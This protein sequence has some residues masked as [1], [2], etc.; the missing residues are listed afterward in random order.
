[1][2]TRNLRALCANHS[3]LALLC[4]RL[5]ALVAALTRISKTCRIFPL[6]PSFW[7]LQKHSRV[8]TAAFHVA[9]PLLGCR[10]LH[11]CCSPDPFLWVV[12]SL[13]WLV[14]SHLRPAREVFFVQNESD[15][16]SSAR[17]RSRRDLCAGRTETNVENRHRSILE[18]G[19]ATSEYLEPQHSAR[20]RSQTHN[21]L[22]HKSLQF[23]NSSH[24]AAHPLTSD[25]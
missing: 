8:S 1:M 20:N 18:P 14:S 13:P 4:S 7:K 24:I 3:P 6:L 21:R 10:V 11:W 25:L 9:A 16:R 5:Q 2:T 23:D 12:I 15:S 19:E 17:L 22:P